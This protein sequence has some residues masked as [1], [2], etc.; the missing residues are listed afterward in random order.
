MAKKHRA[1]S[2][3]TVFVLL[4]LVV[5]VL[6]IILLVYGSMT[7]GVPVPQLPLNRQSAMAAWKYHG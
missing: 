7:N 6:G 3:F 2:P 1:V 5:L 4:M